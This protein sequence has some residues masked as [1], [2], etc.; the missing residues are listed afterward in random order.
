MNE[1]KLRVSGGLQTSVTMLYRAWKWKK[2]LSARFTKVDG[3]KKWGRK[4][5]TMIMKCG[6]I[7]GFLPPG[8]TLGCSARVTGSPVRL[9]EGSYIKN[10]SGKDER[11]GEV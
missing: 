3:E 10:P 2:R 5:K 1:E 11:V 9:C 4:T 6:P 8:Q 7:T